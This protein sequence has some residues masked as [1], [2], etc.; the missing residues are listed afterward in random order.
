[1]S[2]TVRDAVE[3][4][5][6]RLYYAV[7]LRLSW[8]RDIAP[9]A[10]YQM[11]KTG[12]NTI[13]DYLAAVGAD[14]PI[15]HVHSMTPGGF[16]Y[17]RARSRRRGRARP[18]RNYW[19]G[20]FLRR[21]LRRTARSAPPWHVVSSIREPVA[22]NLS[23]F[24]QSLDV[25]CPEFS[26]VH[27]AD[28]DPFSTLMTAFMDRY[29]H[30]RVLHW[31]DNEMRES[32]GIDVFATPFPHSTGWQILEGPAARLLLIR[33]ENVTDCLPDAVASFLPHLARGSVAAAN[34]ANGKPYARTYDRFRSSLVLPDD[35]LSRMYDSTYA[36]HFYTEDERNA[37]R[38]RWSGGNPVSKAEADA[39]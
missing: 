18:G 28:R 31:F 29:P 17:I 37:F 39:P 9:V 7:T 6:A 24:F 27:A 11:G 14:T 12:S 38:A 3:Y 4:A 13:V 30:D 2:R 8:R 15:Y 25:W 20:V 19:E 22:R 1:M 5:A 10:I 26:E 32:L 16:T 23:A 36:T 35:Y 34:T 21:K 33:L